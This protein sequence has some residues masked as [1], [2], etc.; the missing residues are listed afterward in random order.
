VRPLVLEQVSRITN[1]GTG[2]VRLFYMT[3]YIWTITKGLG[4]VC[5][6]SAHLAPLDLMLVKIPSCIHGGLD[7]IHSSSRDYLIEGLRCLSE[8]LSY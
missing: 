1:Y 7:Y 8:G 6:S 2:Y 5:S 4:K 3:P